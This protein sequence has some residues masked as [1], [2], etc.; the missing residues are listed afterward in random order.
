MKIKILIELLSEKGYLQT[1][2]NRPLINYPRYFLVSE[3]CWIDKL[4]LIVRQEGLEPTT[5]GFGGR[6][7]IQIELLAHHVVN[8]YYKFSGRVLFLQIIY[9]L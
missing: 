7:S 8:Y 1:R 4:K 5:Y 9:L 6:H 3:C 2:I